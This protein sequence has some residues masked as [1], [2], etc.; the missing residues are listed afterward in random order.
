MKQ[1]DPI[2]AEVIRCGLYTIANEMSD[3][4]VRTATT[5]TFSESHDFSTSIFDGDGRMISLSD[6]LPMHM[7]A[8]KFS[9]LAAIEFFKDDIHPGDLIVLNDPY[10]GGS[11]IPD[12]TFMSPVFAGD[13]ILF[14]PVIRAHQGDTGGTIPGGYN[15]DASDIWQEG[16]RLPPI[17][18]HDRGVARYDIIK[19]LEINTREPRF[20]GDLKAMTGAVRVGERRLQEMIKRYDP[21]TIQRCM[22][23]II[24]YSERRFR[25]EIVGWPDGVYKGEGYLEHDCKGTKDITVR[26]TVTVKG[27]S[28]KL[29]FT[30]SDPQTPGFINSPVPNSYS[31]IFLTLSSMIDDSIPRNEGLL[32][33][34]EII[35]PPGT[36]VNPLPPA[37]VTACT[38]HIGGEI[39]EAVA[40]ALA[41][42]IPEKA[43][44]QNVKMGMP[45]VT[46]GVNPVSGEFYLDQNT[47]MSAGWCGAAFGVDGWGSLPPYFGAMTMATAE[48]HDMYFPNHTVE[49]E[50]MTD[51]GGPGKWRGGATTLVR[52]KATA[53]MWAHTFAI[54]TKYTMRGIA[55]GKDGPP[56]RF[57]LREGAPNEFVVET[58]GYGV[59]LEAG[60]VV[61]VKFGGGGGWGDPMERDPKLVLEDVIDEYVSLEG[62]RDDY[63]VVIDAGRMALDSGA[64]EKLRARLKDE[65]SLARGS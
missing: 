58:A 63:G 51:S 50:F 16:L 20:V 52:Q 39:G 59:P 22:D 53:L 43:Y 28:L 21:E 24:D 12:W 47:N 42:A 57:V 15:P 37:P 55:G 13:R 5:S 34:V 27:D 25:S 32:R 56:N 31:F 10:H 61:C 7:G 36:V 33:P 26:V 48:L 35:L 19:M 1:V 45:V 40:M 30:G 11:H 46:Y 23:Y 9:V 62:A 18:I 65:R 14:F 64:T 8:S 6:G 3:T 2:T 41:Q 17:K 54:G 44:L 60:D 49:R 38:L 29:D 4:M